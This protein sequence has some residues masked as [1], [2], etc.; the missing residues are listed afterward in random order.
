MSLLALRC[1]SRKPADVWGKMCQL[2]GKNS[3][4]SLA[5]G[6]LPARKAAADLLP[7]H[8]KQPPGKT[9]AP[10]QGHHCL[11]A[12]GTSRGTEPTHLHLMSGEGEKKANTRPQ[13]RDLNGSPPAHCH[14]K[15]AR[16]K[17]NQYFTGLFALV[18]YLFTQIFCLGW[19][20][21]APSWPRRFIVALCL[22]C[23]P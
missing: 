23:L 17:P 4:L 21:N 11:P 18:L 12:P 6:M 19:E 14:G 5:T 20:Q 1:C 22:S 15:V 9:P 10:C 3:K 13:K 8:R 2:K 7:L 16:T